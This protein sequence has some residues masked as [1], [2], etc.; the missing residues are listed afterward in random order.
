[1]IE[2]M[3]A[4]FMDVVKYKVKWLFNILYQIY[5]KYIEL[6]DFSDDLF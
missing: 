4:S 5:N 3:E 1:M 2:Y 6:Y